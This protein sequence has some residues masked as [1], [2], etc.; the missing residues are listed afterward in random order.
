MKFLRVHVATL[1]LAGLATAGI[2]G[3]K[4]KVE[5]KVA[6][7]PPD[8][9]GD[10]II[11]K[12]DACPTDKE[13]GLNPNPTDGCPNLDPD[14]D[15]ILGAADKCPT[16]PETKNGFL[17][18]DGC[19]D[20]KPLV[21][22]TKKTVEISEQIQ[23][24]HNS[25]AIE[26]TSENLLNAL[27][28]VLKDHPEVQLLEVSG[29]ASRDGAPYYNRTLTQKRVDSV[30][31]AMIERGVGKDR[32]IAQGFGFHCPANAAETEA[33]KTANRRVELN[34]L[35][36]EGKALEVKRGCEAAT[37]AGIKLLTLP[38]L[39]VWNP[40]AKA[41][42]AAPAKAEEAAPAKAEAAAPAPK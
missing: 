31:A 9:D 37:S 38:K 30:V 29:H 41:E 7:A 28:K 23:F 19:P 1:I 42:E 17:D 13:D 24:A 39:P 12:D 5:V 15:G 8:T 27:A 26:P 10:G 16:K 32:M 36:R 14:N 35:Y 11:D 33:A 34:I 20:H 22:V 4:A 21:V 2:A 40:P 3:C 25:A 18:D 6:T